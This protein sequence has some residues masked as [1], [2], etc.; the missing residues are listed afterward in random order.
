MYLPLKFSGIIIYFGN[1][2]EII[3]LSVFSSE[4]LCKAVILYP[5]RG[6]EIISSK[7][8]FLYEFLLILKNAQ[9]RYLIILEF[10]Y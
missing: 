7:P 5:K 1:C 9:I 2:G 8:K 10:C 3:L 4:E 6:E